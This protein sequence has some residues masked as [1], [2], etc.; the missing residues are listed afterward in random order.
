MRVRA[1]LESLWNITFTLL[2]QEVA[3]D[4]RSWGEWT[5]I[6]D[7]DFF[8]EFI[9]VF[10]LWRK[11][12]QASPLGLLVDLGRDPVK[13]NL[14][15]EAWVVLICLRYC[16]DYALIYIYLCG[17]FWDPGI[18]AKVLNSFRLCQ[19]EYLLIRDYD[20]LLRVFR[21]CAFN[22]VI[23]KDP[24]VLDPAKG[25]EVSDIFRTQTQCLF[26]YIWDFDIFDVED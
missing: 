26:Q 11:S 18:L 2:P 25:L 23:S 16:N 4:E 17:I 13:V 6:L 5:F 10:I 20:H 12:G 8:V 15:L 1:K 3:I 9:K 22:L 7:L 19:R 24:N 14:S 21:C